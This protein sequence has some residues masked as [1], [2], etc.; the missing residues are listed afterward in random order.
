MIRHLICLVRNASR[1]SLVALLLGT[2]FFSAKAQVNTANVT[3][4]VED[5]SG[6]RIAAANVTLINL[7]TGT[8]NASQSSR[9]GVFVLPGLLPGN[10]T[11][12]IEQDGFAAVQFSGLTLNIGDTK[13]FRVR[14]HIGSVQQT[15][16]VDASGLRVNTEDA[17]ISTV[18]DGRF[19][20]NVPLNGRSFQ[21]L[22]SMTP[23]AI[24]Q[25]PQTGG[26]GDFSINGQTTHT[27]SY[28]VDGVSGNTGPGPLDAENKLASAGQYPGTTSLGTTQ[29][30]V[31]LDALQ[32]FRV[33]GSSYS[34]EY[35]RTSGGQFTLLTRSGTS[36]IHGSAYAYLRNSYYDAGD[37][38]IGFNNIYRDRAVYFYQQ[39]IGGTLSV[40]LDISKISKE[41]NRTF[42]FG[43]YEEL[44]VLQP[45]APLVQYVPSSDLRQQDSTA[46]TKTLLD[47][48]PAFTFSTDSNALTLLRGNQV[49]LPSYVKSLDL[50]ID[51]KL[52]DRLSAFVRY[53]NTP[54]GSQTRQ[55]A[56]LSNTKL[57]SRTITA[58][59]DAQISP[60]MSDEF[61]FGYATSGSQ[62][63]T[64][65]D[66]FLYNQPIDLA[67]ALGIP[68]P[69]LGTRSEVY[70]RIP[71]IGESFVD[72]DR[73]LNSLTQ[74][75]V[76]DTFYRQE[77]DHLIRFG[78]DQRHIDSA[79]QSAP[80]SVEADYLDVAAILNNSASDLVITRSEPAHPTFNEFSAF[81]EDEWKAS[82]RFT[83]SLG[84]RWEI[85]PAP[86]A[87]DKKYAY[88]L[89]GNVNS[90]STL[91][92]APRGTPLWNTDWHALAPRLGAVWAL[93]NQPG[94]ELI[95]RAGGGIFFDTANQAA[96]EAF[97]AAGFSATSHLYNVP[98]PVVPSQLN[99][100]T[101]ATAPYTNTTAYSFASHQTLPY[102]YQ[103]NVSAEKAFS[104]HQI[105]TL[106]YV[107]SAG[108][109]LLQAQ[110]R[111]I[112]NQNPAF[113]EIVYFPSGITSNYQSL[114]TKFQRSVAPGLEVLAS[115]VWSHTFD[116]GSAAPFFPLT[117]GTSDLDVRHNLQAAISWST[118]KLGGEKIIRNA[119]SRWGFDAR[120]TFRTAYPVTPLG[121]WFSDPVTG[122]HFYSGADLIPNRPL[123]LYGSQYPGGRIFNGGPDAVNPAF[124][125]PTG[126]EAGNASR[127]IVRG[128]DAQ[129]LSLAVRRDIRLYNRVTLQLR[130]ESFN[131]SNSPDFGYIS[132]HL[133][134]ALFG[135]PTLSLNQS[136]GQT[137]SLYQLGGPRSLQWMFKVAF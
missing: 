30:L 4:V 5:A 65:L 120:F 23:G 118:P 33:L 71:G 116:Y 86:G 123:Y 29:G 22:I 40:P 104:S 93:S 24:P 58:G 137:G 66:Y 85:D 105:L 119:L 38:F 126:I 115:Y 53:G 17:S 49:S 11:M 135:Q 34:A 39:D 35:G 79:V 9:S 72:T 88:T 55:L 121:N 114:Q 74:T 69:T 27:N 47:A 133:T 98:V 87:S 112:S 82:K 113:S 110:R 101:E 13:S 70:I 108:R 2:I 48:F 128:F 84:L 3:G 96:T 64:G 54:S 62:L 57:Q 99:F 36:Q 59:V 15:I 8:E 81:V 76:K 26:P 125:L 136:F 94:K 32:E 63:T 44:H 102:A 100:T 67:Q 18:V 68:P 132:P 103:W 42:F 78:I 45:T 41:R 1:K 134:D 10:Y 46:Q 80:L 89:R 28:T 83:L 127:N 37:W 109:N 60:T 7:L 20:S 14:L 111:S 50:R 77:R 31:S 90:P 106:S 61:R 73:A 124:Q 16:D 122:E 131:V 75:N 107:G 56:S 12:R 95:L 91:T 97:N 6:A 129:Q 25:S 130:A 52:S 92:L 43:S 117:H 19:V 51:R 21:D